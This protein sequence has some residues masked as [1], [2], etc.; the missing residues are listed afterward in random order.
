LILYRLYCWYGNTFVYFLLKLVILLFLLQFY[1]WILSLRCI[2]LFLFLNFFQLLIL[3]NDIILY[4]FLI[5]ILYYLCSF[6][7]DF[8]FFYININKNFKK[9]TIIIFINKIIFLNFKTFL[10]NNFLFF[11]FIFL[12]CILF[13]SFFHF[14]IFIISFC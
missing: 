6:L 11:G 10:W 3:S 8:N 1:A 7:F 13:L 2:F 14:Y 12:N 5:L 9:L 4:L